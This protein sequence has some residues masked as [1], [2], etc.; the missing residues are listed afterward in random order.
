MDEI[1]LIFTTLPQ[2]LITC[3]VVGVASA[4]YV[5][6]GF[7]SGLVAVGGLALALPG[8]H[9]VVIL[10]LLFNIPAELLVVSKSHKIIS[11]RGVSLICVGVGV[12]LY[13]GTKILVGCDPTFIIVL[14][15]GFLIIAGTAFL[16]VGGNRVFQWPRWLGVPVG[17]VSGVLAG[18]FGTGGPPLIFYYQ[19]AGVAKAT[20]RGNLMAIFLFIT[21][22]RVP[23]CAQ[24]GLITVARLW[25]SLAVMPAVAAGA[26]LGHHIHVNLQ[27]NTFRRLISIALIVLGVILVLRQL[28]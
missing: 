23:L 1:A 26:L 10:I 5:L 15:G 14:L 24:E 18:L 12:G 27:E 13:I 8:I 2:Y 4:V 6:F 3:L 16:L 19:L 21:L 9:D 7:G 25:S 20:F 28:L 22:L 11:L 17:L